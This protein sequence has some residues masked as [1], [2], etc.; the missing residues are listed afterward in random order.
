MLRLLRRE[1]NMTKS[2]ICLPA[3]KKVYPNTTKYHSSEVTQN[4]ANFT[5]GR[6]ADE[7]RSTKAVCISACEFSS[8][9]RRSQI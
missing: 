3:K 2:D 8:T 6:A 1:W 5:F 7:L 4:I 9:K